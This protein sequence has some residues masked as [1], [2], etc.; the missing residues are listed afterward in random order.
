MGSKVV[1]RK[2]SRSRSKSFFCSSVFQPM[3]PAHEF[4]AL[5]STLSFPEDP[6]LE[7][8]TE[9]SG[10]FQELVDEGKK[11]IIRRCLRLHPFVN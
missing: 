5:F 4:T 9:A 3:S 7:D 8:E 10:M 11:N 6:K 1:G 2:G